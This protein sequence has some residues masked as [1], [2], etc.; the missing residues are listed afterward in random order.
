MIRTFVLVTLI[1]ML[2]LPAK[3][4]E[5]ESRFT[6]G[7]GAGLANIDF[8]HGFDG[9]DTALS[10]FA[11]YDFNRYFSIETSYV[12]AGSAEENTVTVDS[13]YATI[14]AIGS[15]PLWRRWSI[16]AR[17]GVA[18]GSWESG[19]LERQDTTVMLGAGT[20]FDF[21]RLRL[22][23]IGDTATLE[24][25]HLVHLSVRAAWKF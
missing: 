21:E 18:S 19:G 14:M 25:A 8:D 22:Q 12:D 6:L 11:A 13:S 4:G 16:S 24:D 5:R 9:N 15:W 2:A 1:A 20:A 17:V 7:L 3:A 10:V 23:L